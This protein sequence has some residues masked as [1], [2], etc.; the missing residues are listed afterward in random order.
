M[1]LQV[2]HAALCQVDVRRTEDTEEDSLRQQV[3]L[4]NHILNT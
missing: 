3:Y 1:A 2:H 4:P